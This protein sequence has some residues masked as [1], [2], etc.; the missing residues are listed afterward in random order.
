M[1]LAISLLQQTLAP[2]RWTRRSFVRSK[3]AGIYD[4]Y[5]DATMIPK[6]VF[7]DNL[8]LARLLVRDQRFE[9]HSVVECG[10][11]RGGMS[12]ALIEVCGLRS[13][14]FFDSFAGLPDAKNVDG[15][16]ALRWQADKAGPNYFNNCTASVEEFM[17]TISRTRIDLK[18]VQVHEGLFQHTIPNVDVG[19]IALL[20]LDGDWYDSTMICLESFFPRVAK[21]GL[22]V[23]DDYGTW[24]GCTRAVHDYLSRQHRPEPVNRHGASCVA[25]IQILDD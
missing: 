11:W 13:Y 5:R 7:I 12:A 17:S 2:L 10:T 23:I 6:E 20:R 21:G 8:E 24:D 15:K 14:H 25:F 3:L 16:A 18:Y 9:Y 22:I 1:P 4:R 19:P